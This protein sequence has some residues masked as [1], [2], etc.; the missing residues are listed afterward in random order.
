MKGKEK[1]GK[2]KKKTTETPELDM[3]QDSRSPKAYNVLQKEQA[4]ID[5]HSPS[6]EGH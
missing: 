6:H 1:K 4:A 5:S 3:Q 2:K